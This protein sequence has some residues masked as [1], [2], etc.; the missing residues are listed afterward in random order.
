M[1]VKNILLTTD[2]SKAAQKAYPAAAAIARKFSATL[3]LVYALEPFPALAMGAQGFSAGILAQ[4]Y[5]EEIRSRLEAH[6]Q[7]HSALKGLA[8]VP[9]LV[10]EP[11]LAQ[12]LQS[13]ERDQKIDLVVL[14]THGRTGIEYALL[15]SFAHKMVRYS[16]APVLAYRPVE[17]GKE[18]FAP[19]LVLVPFD[20]SE[21]ARAV[22]PMTQFLA[23]SYGSSF[24]FIFV[25]EP[26]MPVFNEAIGPGYYAMLEE[27]NKNARKEAQQRFAALQ[28]KELEGI[29]SRLL[30]CEG[31]PVAEILKNAWEMKADCILLATHGWTG[32]R[33]LLLGSVAERVATKAHCSVLT[34]RAGGK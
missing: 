26:L 24:A 1:D 27:A 9:H 32:L 14:S 6:A 12:V 17:G 15:G 25:N 31:S 22:F 13:F 3:H 33:H 5:Q 20:F 10:S 7:E 4:E 2:F 34:V 11:N 29:T 8:V 21:N 30:V 23:R 16:A 19:R 18:A 28:E